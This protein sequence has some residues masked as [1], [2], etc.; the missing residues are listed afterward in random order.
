MAESAV[1]RSSPTKQLQNGRDA[2][3]TVVARTIRDVTRAEIEEIF[4]TGA[5]WDTTVLIKRV[6][7]RTSNGGRGVAVTTFLFA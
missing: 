1:F 4:V 3:Q 6:D 5:E 2:F 7:Y